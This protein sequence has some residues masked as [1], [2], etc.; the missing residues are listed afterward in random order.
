[1]QSLAGAGILIDRLH[2]QPG[3]RVLDVGCGPGRLTIPFAKYVG[4]NGEV[5]ALDIQPRMLQELQR[6]VKENELA[7]VRLVLGGAG[8]GHLQ[9]RGAF[10]RAVL[11]TVLGEIPDRKKALQEIYHALRPGGLLSITELLPDPDYQT[12]RTVLRL[13]REAGFE[14]QE[15]YGNLIVFTLNFS[16]PERRLLH[17]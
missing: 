17:E 5:V 3:M 14:L 1:M 6:R 12:R 13:A 10:D 15:K 11:V 2:L 4:R 9:E 7:N 16:K 8:A